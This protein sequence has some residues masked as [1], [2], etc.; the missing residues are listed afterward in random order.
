MRIFGLGVRTRAPAKTLISRT[1]HDV[2]PASSRLHQRNKAGFALSFVPIALTAAVSIACAAPPDQELLVE[3]QEPHTA[4][5]IDPKLLD[6]YAGFYRNPTTGSLMVVTRDGDHL[7]TRRAGNP[8]VPEYAYTDHDFFLTSAPQQNTF[9]TDAMGRVIRVVHHQMGLHEILERMSAEDGECELAVI[10]ERLK[11][12]RGAHTI[13]NIDPKLLDAYE[14]FYRNAKTGSLMVVT[15]DGDHLLT[16]RAGNP[17]VP[18]YPYSDRDFFLTVAPQQNRFVT[19]DSGAVIR[20]VHH[21]MGQEETLERISSEEGQRELANITQRWAAQ[22]EPHHVVSVDPHLIDLYV[23]RYRNS[24]WEISVTR[25]GNQL[26][27]QFTGYARYP[28]YPFT[29]HDFFATI[30]PMQISFLSDGFGKA[31]QLVRHQ[32]GLDTVLI[33]FE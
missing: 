19:D 7:L 28:V 16:R 10:T 26:F 8:P 27:V 23:G 2:Q 17:P 25:E 20:V 18:E 32:F 24:E 29:D 3:Q 31:T 9:V 15:R 4:I 13:V 5:T 22:L 6:A 1:P 30:E 21:Q 33:R 11:A 14:G 12:E